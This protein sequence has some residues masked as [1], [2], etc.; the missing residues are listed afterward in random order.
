MNQG[1]EKT[2][3][4]PNQWDIVRLENDQLRRNPFTAFTADAWNR[5]K[6]IGDLNNDEKLLNR[7]IIEIAK[8]SEWNE[9]VLENRHDSGMVEI[10]GIRVA[11][12]I[13][14][15][16]KELQRRSETPGLGYETRRVLCYALEKDM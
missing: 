3:K 2:F 12:R 5:I 7:A 8:F 9:E 15:Y 1:P 16:D 13:E 11:W 14:Y 6:I 4:A 10:D